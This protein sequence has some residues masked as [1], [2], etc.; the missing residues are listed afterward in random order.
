MA[1]EQLPS[2]NPELGLQPLDE[3]DRSIHVRGLDL[4][5][6]Q[7]GRFLLRN[8]PKR[9][10]KEL[11]A[12]PDEPPLGWGLHFEEEVILP[13]PLKYTNVFISIVI[14]LSAVVYAFVKV[15]EKGV[16]AFSAGNFGIAIAAF[17]M[18]C[19]LKFL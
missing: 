12:H 8:T 4:K 6:G 19:A 7:R 14:M 5:P 3:H 11:K 15:R 18:T 9:I 2:T 17:M 10:E 13:A 16:G 1:P